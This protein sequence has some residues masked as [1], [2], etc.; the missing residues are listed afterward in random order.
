MKKQTA[1]VYPTRTIRLKDKPITSVLVYLF[2]E[3]FIEFNHLM[4]TGNRKFSG[5][6][7]LQKKTTK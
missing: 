2:D 6:V 7:T 4:R 3:N 1:N 5:T